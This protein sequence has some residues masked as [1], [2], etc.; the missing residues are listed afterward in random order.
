M[1]SR[2]PCPRYHD[3][4]LHH[5]GQDTDPDPEPHP[6]A[7]VSQ[8]AIP[9]NWVLSI[10]RYED[11][12][13]PG[14]PELCVTI[15]NSER[16]RIICP[17]QYLLSTI[18]GLRTRRDTAALSYGKLWHEMKERGVYPAW[19]EE[20]PP[21]RDEADGA[22]AWAEARVLADMNEGRL[23]EE[24]AFEVISKLRDNLN[25]WLHMTGGGMP[26]T[27]LR[28]VGYE[29][30]LAMPICSPSGSVY[31]PEMYVV[32]DRNE[33]GPYIRL[34][35]SGEQDRA[36][37]VRLPWY[38]IGRLDNLFLRVF[39]SKPGVWV[40]D[41]KT[42]KDPVG[43]LTRLANDPQIPSYLSLVRYNIRQGHLRHLGIEPGTPVLG[44]WHRVTSSASFS[45]VKHLKRAPKSGP[46]AG[47]SL[48]VDTRQR[49][50]S[51]VFERAVQAVGD[52]VALYADFVEQLRV[53]VDQ[54]IEH[55]AH[56]DY[57]DAD[58]DRFERE[59]YADAQA[60]SR[61]WRAALRARSLD[62]I[63]KSHPRR[64]VCTIPGARCDFMA[65]C[66]RDGEHARS[67]FDVRASLRWV[68]NTPPQATPEQPADGA[69]DH[70]GP[71]QNPDPDPDLGW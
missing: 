10:N 5:D 64:P 53:K 38:F 52:D 62:D 1:V 56:T 30:P 61:M 2:G 19:M 24:D 33:E 43:L 68:P 16:R 55:T 15:S 35:R 50:P 28:M 34:A 23:D 7:V 12:R 54:N 57:P 11:R 9:D 45:K 70:G 47:M 39:G 69:T 67:G 27:T 14:L 48:S 18:E 29:V 40:A 32:D 42:S 37:K 22:I 63:D 66:M 20:R 49:I 6:G 21:T 44:F 41:D 71:I 46:K 36:R 17:R 13:P 51:W 59:V 3:L 31:R 4:K 65:P 25:A 60:I 58:L 8:P 26:P